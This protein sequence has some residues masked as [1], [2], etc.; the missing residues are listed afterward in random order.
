LRPWFAG[1]LVYVHTTG[2]VED[3][4]QLVGSIAEGRRRYLE[5]E[6]LERRVIS[7]GT[8]SASVQGR[9]RLAVAAPALTAMAE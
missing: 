8:G 5:V 3:R 1:D 2:E 4:E 6:P 9:V 7:N